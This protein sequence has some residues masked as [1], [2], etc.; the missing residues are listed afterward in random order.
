MALYKSAQN[1]M[2]A[3][4]IE[5]P[6]E[7]LDN[8]V[9]VY[10]QKPT[11]E[12]VLEVHAPEEEIS[13]SD[14]D[15]PQAECEECHH[16]EEPKE[17]VQCFVLP[18]IPGAT[19][20]EPIEVSDDEDRGE[21]EIGT[22]AKSSSDPWKYELN[23]FIEWLQDRMANFPRHS[24]NDLLGLERAISYAKKL[25]QEATSAVRQDLKG[26][27]DINKASDALDKLYDGLH[28]L[29]ERRD[30]VQKTKYKRKKKAGDN[31]EMIKEA[32][33]A[34]GV[35]GVI[36]TVP[37]LISSVARAL[38]NGTISSGR[39]MEDLYKRA[40]KVHKL[41]LNQQTELIQLLADMNFPMKRDFIYAPEDDTSDPDNGS[42]ITNY[43]A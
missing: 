27:I 10:E 7:E 21:E 31:S 2:D 20:L 18:L 5:L 41:D 6:Q 29:E 17:D 42:L 16:S 15:L 25:I 3:L 19:N 22:N 30:D 38:I 9:V 40:V 8:K 13:V 1:I 26:E 37:L 12:E 24:G 34:P 14:E 33:K 23:N 39:D 4:K 35:G 28:R 11:E 36:V 32:Q 43:S